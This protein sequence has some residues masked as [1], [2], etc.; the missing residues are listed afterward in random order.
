MSV[1]ISLC[2]SICPQAY[3]K[4]HISKARYVSCARWL[5][6]WIGPPLT[7]MRWV[8]NSRLVDNVAFS[9]NKQAQLT[10]LG[11][12]VQS[13]L[14]VPCDSDLSRVTHHGAPSGKVWQLR[15]PCLQDNNKD[16][17][18]LTMT[19]MMKKMSRANP[20]VTAIIN[21]KAIV[22][23]TQTHTQLGLHYTAHSGL[24]TDTFL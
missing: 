2:T 5:C 20:T 4:N 3:L 23:N 7:T 14:V 17:R 21:T 9:N 13:A 19:M 11:R 8:M 10:A 6:P 1:Y 15:L 18:I 12:Y 24:K 16:L 22:N